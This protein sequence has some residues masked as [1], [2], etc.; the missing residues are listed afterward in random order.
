MPTFRNGQEDAYYR[1]S[2]AEIDWLGGWL[3]RNDAVLGIREH[4]ADNARVYTR[5]LQRLAPLDLSDTQFPD[6]E[7]LYRHAALLVTDYSSCFI[8][9][10]LTGRPA[11]S[12]AYDHES[13]ASIERGFFYDLDMVFPGPVC[14]TFA[15]LQ[16]G[17]EGA[18][19]APAAA[20]QAALDLKRRIFFDHV[21]DHNAARLVA[22]VKRLG[23][24]DDIGRHSLAIGV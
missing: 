3:Q 19:T 24:F 13:Y 20:A 11:V 4:M 7:L 18:F 8:D 22:R 14:R 21:D 10:M 2:D 17:L 9:F 6:A 1:F 15:E 16:A 12:F 5:M 23:D